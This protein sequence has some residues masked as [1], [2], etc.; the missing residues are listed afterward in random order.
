MPLR[1]IESLL[2]ASRA[3]GRDES[4]V[5]WG[6][7]N[8]SVKAEAVTF[9][10]RRA[11]ALYVKGSGSDMKTL[12]RRHLAV[13]DLEAI[14]ELR[15]RAAMTDEE[16]VA[17]L[18]AC[19]LE[20]G[21]RGSIE[22]LLHAFLPA[23]FVLHTHAD[24]TAVLSDNP[25]SKKHVS[26]CWQGKVA[27]LPYQRPGFA[28]SVAT[29]AA[30]DP[31]LQGIMLDK[32]G[33]ITWGETGDEALNK[34]KR[35]VGEAA[36]YVAR[37][38]RPSAALQ[39]PKS[40]WPLEVL[41]GALSRSQ[42]Q[43]LNM[44]RS[45]EAMAFSLR[46]DAARLCAGGPATPDHLL[47]TKPRALYIEDPS[48]IEAKVAH[49][50]K[51]YGSYFKKY[52][53]K[54]SI[55]LDSAP[56]IT[57]LRGFGVVT[58]GKDPRQA[59]I[60][61]DIFRHSMKVRQG[62]A[63]LGGYQSIGIGHIADFEYW[64]LENYKLSLAPPEKELSRK[65]AVVTGAARGIGKACAQRLAEEGACVAILDLDLKAAQAVAAGLGDG[66]LAIRCDVS[67]EAAVKRAFAQVV[68]AWGGLD[69]LVSNAGLARVASV[70]KMA[71]KDWEQSF[72]VNARG[73]FLCCRE[74]ARIFK[75]QGIGGNVVV[76]SSKNVLAPGKDFGAY[77][78][79]KAA[80]TQLSK[81]LALELAEFGVRVNCVTPD[82]VF[83][84]S[85]LWDG[86][87]EGRAKAHGISPSALEAFYVN[88]NL[89]KR[90]IRPADVAEAVL[91]LASERSSRTTG[92]LLAVDGGVKEAFPR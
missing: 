47:Y 69:L 75:A 71:L 55:K 87:R 15:R 59:L 17:Y 34:M 76:V 2:K 81:V 45:A 56:R 28:L 42:P 13:L 79:S 41:R 83:E 3:V 60:V 88:R 8:S 67:N 14:L 21:P 6:G 24:A 65:I 10:G 62:A 74:A 43:I 89:L 23:K 12:E 84:D 78:A 58:A 90:Q 92:T 82:G 16:M 44:D 26:A 86:I 25:Q 80:Q 36:R 32:H 9:R 35:L 29:A 73:H 63:G 40:E 64:P 30:Y 1:D 18:A 22:T 51:W 70:A 53:P 68:Q 38:K 85:R 52:A 72:A 49:Y 33:L 31:A 7:G 54:G 19:Q 27:L 20:P 37:R 66:G 5:V 11:R 50:R 4:L 77:S 57:V 46:K 61:R 91:F 39:R 48:R